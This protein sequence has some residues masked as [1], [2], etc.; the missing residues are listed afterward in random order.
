ME[1]W[2]MFP[3]E[4]FPNY[5]FS[6]QHE[7]VFS[8]NRKGTKELKWY[9]YQS[10]IKRIT[11]YLAKQPYYVFLNQFTFDDS[12]KTVKI[13]EGRK[14]PRQVKVVEKVSEDPV[15]EEMNQVIEFFH[16]RENRPVRKD[17]FTAKFSK[18]IL[19][20]QKEILK[21]EKTEKGTFYSLIQR[22]YA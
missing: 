12:S 2:I 18:E 5:Y 17:G 19:E 22:F 4:G 9:E 13:V 7:I 10:G 15:S 21:E 3:I 1:K 20:R 8:E 14:R 11:L 6:P 16:Q